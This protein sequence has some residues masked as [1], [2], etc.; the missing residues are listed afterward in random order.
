VTATTICSSHDRAAWRA[1]RTLHVGASDVPVLFGLGYAD[2]SVERLLA[3]KLGEDVGDIADNSPALRE[4]LD[5]GNALEPVILRLAGERLGVEVRPAGV[6]LA[7]GIPSAT[8]DGWADLDGITV[9]VEI[10]N[11]SQWAAHEWRDGPP[12]RVLLQVQA[13]LE[14]TE[15]PRAIVA[16]LLAGAKLG[17][18]LVER[19]EARG[20]EIR[21]VI[22]SWWARHVYERQ[23]LAPPIAAEETAA[24]LIDGAE[25][26][27]LARAVIA[28]DR[29]HY[30]ASKA[31]DIARAALLAAVATADLEVDGRTLGG[32]R[33]TYK[34]VQR[35][36]ESAPRPASEF[37]QLRVTA[38][39]GQKDKV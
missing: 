38:P 33:V 7:R 18:W 39:K 19:D 37:W 11:V 1:A 35:K 30:E 29:A 14:V 8:V 36:A 4:R 24:P 15:A 20:R 16:A 13:Q 10:K 23:P 34:R 28:A 32:A 26:D 21:E 3:E 6:M 12:E 27:E 17:T 9:P 22:E 5:L 31:R 25:I 2:Q